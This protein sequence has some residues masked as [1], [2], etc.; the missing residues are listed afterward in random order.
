MDHT[1]SMTCAA[2]ILPKFGTVEVLDIGA[3]ALGGPA[4][5]QPLIDY[6]LCHLV[7]FEPQKKPFDHLVSLNH[8]NATYVIAAVGD[9]KTHPLC[10]YE[11]S[12]LSSF[13]QL[14]HENVDTLEYNGSELVSVETLK[15]EKLD[16]ITEIKSIDYLKI[17][18]QGS[19]LMI[20]KGGRK[21]ISESIGHT[22]R[23]AHA[24]PVPRRTFGR[25]CDELAR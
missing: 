25:G 10:C 24:T 8:P 22:H 14:R 11:S 12:G 20:L 7:G 19:E 16:S 5:Y 15:T 9:G 23:N 1:K 2:R 13:F 17:D 18:T 21:K 4:P 6:G 3:N